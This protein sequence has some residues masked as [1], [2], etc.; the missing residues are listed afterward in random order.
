ML[1]DV[2]IAET[3][4]Q[5]RGKQ[6]SQQFTVVEAGEW[7]TSECSEGDAGHES[8]LQKQTHGEHELFYRIKPYPILLQS[9]VGK[10][11]PLLS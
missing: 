6:N 1:I 3:M 5:A 2:S 11:N 7:S 9:L 4:K 10:K 8:L